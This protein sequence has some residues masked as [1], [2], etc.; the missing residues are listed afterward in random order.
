MGAPAMIWKPTLDCADVEVSTSFWTWL[1]GVEVT[2][3]DPTNG[4]RFLGLAGAPPVMCLQPV[5]EPRSGKNR[6]HLDLL[7]D[8]L[9]AVVTQVREHGGAHLAGPNVIPGGCWSVMADPEGNEFCL[10]MLST[11]GTPAD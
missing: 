8:D 6:M 9:D 1:L 5:K 10:V 7:V 2:L 4:I 3:A 11:E